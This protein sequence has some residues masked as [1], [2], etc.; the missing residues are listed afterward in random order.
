[1]KNPPQFIVCAAMRKGTIIVAGARHFDNVMRTCIIAM[2][3]GT[4]EWEQGFIDQK[5]TFLTRKEAWKAA[6]KQNQIRRLTGWEE[7]Y[8]P[9]NNAGL[10]TKGL[11][12]SENLY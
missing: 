10:S 3:L 4:S 1:M 6:V 9:I 7:S 8:G 5:G 12:F 11:L 2:N